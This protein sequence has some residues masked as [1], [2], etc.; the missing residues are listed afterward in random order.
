MRPDT[1]DPENY[2]AEETGMPNVSEQI[3]CREYAQQILDK[4]NSELEELF[5][6]QPSREEDEV[7]DNDAKAAPIEYTFQLMEMTICASHAIETSEDLDKII[8]KRGITFIRG[9]N[10]L[11][12]DNESGNR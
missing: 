10:Y 8:A 2:D 9:A 3:Q 12:E 4:V 7:E 11:N 5:G 6:K 1:K